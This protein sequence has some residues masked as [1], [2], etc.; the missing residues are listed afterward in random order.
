MRRCAA[1]I[2]F[3]LLAA[4]TLAGCLID[5]TLD[6]DGGGTLSVKVRLMNLDQ[7]ADAKKQMQ[8][9]SVSL[10]NAT[11]DD[12]KWA[13]FSLKFADVTKL[14]T[15]QFF[16]RAK[17]TLA[18]GE[19]GTKI[20]TVTYAN[21]PSSPPLTKEMADYFGNNM[22]IIMHLPGEV[23][24]SNATKTEGNTVT[25]TYVAQEFSKQPQVVMNATFKKP[26]S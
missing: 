12:D 17:V 15:T 25:W 4:L 11:I 2:A 10:V 22:S 18:D 26:A 24:K 21:P 9:A 20:L 13:T 16:D 8:S 7:M 6:K 14:S 1:H 23:V 19:G 5:G 3:V